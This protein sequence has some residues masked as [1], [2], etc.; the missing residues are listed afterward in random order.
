MKYSILA[1]GLSC[2]GLF[3][4]G[5][6]LARGD[7]AGEPRVIVDGN[8]RSLGTS[9][10]QLA[11]TRTRAGVAWIFDHGCGDEV[12]VQT[13]LV[14]G[15]AFPSTFSL[16]LYDPP[17][18]RHLIP[19]PASASVSVSPSSQSSSSDCQPVTNAEGYVGIA[20]IVVF[21]DV[22][23][24][25]AFSGELDGA[26]PVGPNADRV[27]GLAPDHLLV[28]AQNVAALRTAIQNRP[29]EAR[30]ILNPEDL[31]DGYNLVRTVCREDLGWDSGYDQMR[32]V[33]DE[34]IDVVSLEDVEAHDWY[35]LNIH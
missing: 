1:V 16:A 3:A 5:D 19:I 17:S 13:A 33:P 12:A 8:I 20:H 32:V 10:G 2:L 7:Y 22:D 30:S 6:P 26:A 28:Y 11:N 18:R 35:C 29:I 14:T 25:D 23:A 31:R 24:D 15:T 9:G 27:R 34:P 21:D 4:C